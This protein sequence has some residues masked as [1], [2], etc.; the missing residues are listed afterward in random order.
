M[1]IDGRDASTTAAALR[2][3]ANLNKT[4]NFDFLGRGQHLHR[5]PFQMDHSPIPFC[6]RSWEKLQGRAYRK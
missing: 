4:G 1:V 5:D 2:A 6:L 3:F